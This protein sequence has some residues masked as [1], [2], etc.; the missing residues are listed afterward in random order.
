MIR[1]LEPQFAVALL[2]IQLVK[3]LLP[4]PICS[5]LHILLRI[6]LNFNMARSIIWVS[7]VRGSH[8]GPGEEAPHVSPPEASA[9]TVPRPH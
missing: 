3:F 7:G 8:T 9:P 6:F 5:I 4:T 1:F 2:L